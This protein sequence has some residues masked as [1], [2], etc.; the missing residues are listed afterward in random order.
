MLELEDG[1]SVAQL[2]IVP[3]ITP[4][5]KEVTELP[6]STRGIGGFGSSGETGGT[7]AQ[8]DECK[9]CYCTAIVCGCK[10]DVT[11]LAGRVRDINPSTMRCRF[12][13][14]SEDYCECLTKR[15]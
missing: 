12:C 9:D 15:K 4:L 11:R 3:F 14:R 6:Y 8:K 5:L 13:H 10:N 1:Q 2:V 7:L